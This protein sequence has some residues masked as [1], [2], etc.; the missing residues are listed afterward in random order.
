MVLLSVSDVDE[1]VVSESSVVRG[2]S[3][4]LCRFES[5]DPW[6]S[7]ATEVWLMVRLWD[8]GATIVEEIQETSKYPIYVISS[9]LGSIE[10]CYV[11]GEDE[12]RGSA[13]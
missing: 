13:V 3:I 4:C 9:V 1:E 12:I 8:L 7:V 11:T 6:L 2:D 10:S 5:T